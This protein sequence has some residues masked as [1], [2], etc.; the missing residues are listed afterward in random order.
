MV[1]ETKIPDASLGTA[2]RG[3]HYRADV[4][5]DDET[6]SLQPVSF[7]SLVSIPSPLLLPL[8]RH[9]NDRSVLAALTRSACVSRPGRRG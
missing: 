8:D 9:T 6:Q 5:E 2:D 3:D 1:G 7:A 4:P